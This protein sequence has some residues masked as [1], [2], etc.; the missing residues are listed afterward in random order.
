MHVRSYVVVLFLALL[1]SAWLSELWAEGPLSIRGK[2]TEKGGPLE[3]AYVAAHATGKTFTN[4]VMTDSSGQFT[5]RGLA[6]GGYAV[7]TRIPGF[8]TVQKD[9]ISVQ[10]GKETVADF[11]V[12]PET[13]FL[14]LVEQASNSELTESF[15]LAKTHKEAL[16]YRC[17]DCHGAY[18]IAKTRFTPKDWM[19]IISKMDDRGSITPAGDIVPPTR[20]QSPSNRD[21]S[22]GP[23]GSDD[24]SI[25]GVLA[26]FRGPDS[27]DF[28]IKFQPRATGK[29]TRA[30]VT[31]YQIPRRGATPRYV[32]VDPRGRYVWY[33]D[34]RANYLGRIDI[35]TGEIK[36]YP[37]PGRD[38]RPPGLQ[39]LGWD[40][41]GNLWAGQIWS[42][43]AV[44]FDVKSERVTGVWAPPQEWV[45]LGRVRI[46]RS[47]PE[48]PVTYQVRDALISPGGTRWI[49]DPE[50]GNFTEIKERAGAEAEAAHP[51][52]AVR[53]G[54]GECDENPWYGGWRSKRSIFYRDPETGKTTEFPT[55][56]PWS[57]PFNAVGDP[58]RKVGWAAPDVSHRIVKADLK[59]GEVTEF[60][61]PSHG[62]EIRNIDIEMSANPPAL[63]FVNQ[64]LGRIVR[65]QEYTE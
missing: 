51:A 12:E 1:G 40:P 52:T 49:L 4:Y 5:F 22:M 10:V 64:R 18:Y 48:G 36:E 58:V 6:P 9:G 30:V 17:G 25:A 2:V 24:Q 61:L 20:R 50:T 41:M 45:R 53:R 37:I 19:L 29:L 60:P 33:S 47:H 28:P 54:M 38:D 65:F 44:R 14:A 15:P 34:W 32:V 46:C 21:P 8:R 26:Q 62:K 63:W 7:F 56:D 11:Q 23:A 59:T 35:Q 42:G 43:R 27:R 55:L 57:R 3:G 31:E 13:D 16:D 39:A